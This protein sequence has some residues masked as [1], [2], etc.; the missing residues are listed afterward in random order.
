MTD[1]TITS[2]EGNEND[3]DSIETP[4]PL[5]GIIGF[6]ALIFLMILIGGRIGFF[7][8]IPSIAMVGGGT[9]FLSMIAF[10]LSHVRHLLSLILQIFSP[11]TS[12]VKDIT[13][14]DSK[15]LHSMIV[16]LYASGIIG[17]FI[18]AVQL[19]AAVDRYPEI[20]APIATMLLCPFYSLILAEGIMRPLAHHMENQI[21]D[22]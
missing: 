9:I 7:V 19:L 13:P 3:L 14:M 21:N 8:N 6:F 12:N 4:F 1:E 10:N 18:G 11:F 17:V 15:V 2:E 5:L 22:Q 20:G 16:F